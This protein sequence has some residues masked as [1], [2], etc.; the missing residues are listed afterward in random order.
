MSGTL[1]SWLTRMR[2][3]LP[4]RR[5]QRQ[6]GRHER[7]SQCLY[8]WMMAYYEAGLAGKTVLLAEP[9]SKLSSAL[10]AGRAPKPSEL[11]HVKADSAQGPSAQTDRTSDCSK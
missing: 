2:T 1:G 10:L 7:L 9:A 5:R 3:L 6:A 4:W 11:R 8:L